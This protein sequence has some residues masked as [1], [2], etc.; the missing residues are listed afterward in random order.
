MISNSNAIK[1]I[2]F[3]ITVHDYIYVLQKNIVRC[4][5]YVFVQQKKQLCKS[6]D[7]IAKG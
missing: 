1:V 2:Q 3:K 7:L 5:R 4:L 6:N